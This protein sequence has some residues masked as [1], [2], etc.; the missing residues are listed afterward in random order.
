MKLICLNTWG[1]RAGRDKL[2]AFLDA[3][4]DALNRGAITMLACHAAKAAREAEA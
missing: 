3:Q 4:R 1:G 2:L